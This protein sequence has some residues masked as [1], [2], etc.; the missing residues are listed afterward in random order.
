VTATQATR[1]VRRYQDALQLQEWAVRVECVPVPEL[2]EDGTTADVYY[3]HES[4]A[5][6]VR[7]ATRRDDEA[8]RRDLLHE[9]LHLGLADLM[10]A[11]ELLKAQVGEAAWQVTRAALDAANERFVIR[12]VRA[13]G[14]TV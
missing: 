8:I 4:M 11:A 7:V 6:T 5:A 10:G 12:A 13:F 3:S 1:C 14:G 9:V 2:S